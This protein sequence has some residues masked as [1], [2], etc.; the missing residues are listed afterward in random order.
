M[1]Q[2]KVHILTEKI[3]DLKRDKDVL[4]FKRKRALYADHLMDAD[5]YEWER[6]EV[7]E[8]I[9]KLRQELINLLTE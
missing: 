5:Q 1:E 2:D 6:D 4:E 9:D 8:E 7:Q 3:E